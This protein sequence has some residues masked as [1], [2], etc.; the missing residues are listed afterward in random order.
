MKI[1]KYFILIPLLL[2]YKVNSQDKLT[3]SY[4]VV[5]N[6]ERPNTQ[7]FTLYFDKNADKSFFVRT[8]ELSN[9]R[10]KIIE[11]K[12][13]NTYHVSFKYTAP[14]YNYFD[15]S[16]DSLKSLVN[17]RI[18]YLV[19][20]TIPLISWEFTDEE[21][22]IDSIRVSKA[23][24]FFRGRKYIAW[25][26]SEYPVKAG[27]W[28]LHGLPGLIFEAYDETRR[29]NWHLKKISYSDFSD[30][31]FDIPVKKI[32]RITLKDYA[33]IRYGNR[34]AQ[35]IVSKLPQGAVFVR[36]SG[37]PRNDKETKFEWER[38]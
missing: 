19:E 25:Y 35:A 3:A 12:D 6:T 31:V 10:E 11:K 37:S 23:T 29:F 15:F 20:E 34:D 14:D 26:S 5:Y 36:S 7:Q 16:T 13:E 33:E 17:L 24:T 30:T 27:P 4:E 18:S 1:F 2:S 8:M 22:L 32:A 9:T 38:Q 28:K 21:K